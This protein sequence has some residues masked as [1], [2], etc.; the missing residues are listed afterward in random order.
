MSANATTY[1]YLEPHIGSSY[2]QLFIKGTKLR[3]DIIYSAAY[4]RGDEDDR[5]P[6]QVA[7]DYG[8]P[9]EAVYEAIRYCESKPVEVA[10]DQRVSDL[11]ADAL[12][13]NDPD[14]TN[15]VEKHRRILG[16]EVRRRIQEQAA[17]ELGLQ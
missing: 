2:K 16:P 7:D 10:Y 5:T 12:G 11:L 9:V 4:Q 13:A 15:N 3:A 1:Q 8:I 17:R 6:E 14:Y